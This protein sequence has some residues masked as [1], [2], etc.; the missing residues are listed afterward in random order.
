MFTVDNGGHQ[1]GILNSWKEIAHYLGRGVRTVQRWEAELGLP[2]HRPRGR[3]RSAVIAVAA[4]LD[5]WMSATPLHVLESRNSESSAAVPMQVLVIEDRISDLNSCVGA[6]RRMGA[7]QVDALSS[8]PAALARLET[9]L[10]GKLPKPD[11]MI[12]DLGFSFSS[13][14]EVLRYLRAHPALMSIPVIVWT[15]MDQHRQELC[16]VYGVR[17]VVGKLAGPRELQEAVLSARLPA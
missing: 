16:E 6:L 4:E 12:L 3:S 10:A 15:L 17:Q 11:L 5:R 13:G 7:I 14:F 9:I 8:I 1:Q 2:V